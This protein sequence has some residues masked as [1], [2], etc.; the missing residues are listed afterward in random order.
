MSN[1]YV[2]AILDARDAMRDY[3]MPS[4]WEAV[5]PDWWWEM[6]EAEGALERCQKLARELFDAELVRYTP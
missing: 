4:P 2:Q 6:A 3:V 1:E 5:M